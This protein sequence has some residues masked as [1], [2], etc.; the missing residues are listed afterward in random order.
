LSVVIPVFNAHRELS[1]CLAS[2]AATV[3]PRTE[4]IIIDDA[5]TEPE[6]TQ[7]L[8]KWRHDSGRA[9]RFHSNPVNRGFVA[10]A[11]RGMRLAKHDVILLNSDTVVTPRWLDGLRECLGSDPSIATA[12]PWTNNG[13]IVSIPRFCENNPAPEDPAAVAA[14]IAAAGKPE[15]PA[16]HTAVGFCMAIS[17]RA[18]RQV[19]LFDAE[20]FG[21]GYGEEN[22]FC[23]RAEAAGWR[24]VLCDDVYVAHLGGRSFGPAGLAP[25]DSSMQRLLSLHPGYL[26][27]IRTWIDADPLAGRRAAILAALEEAGLT[28]G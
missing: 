24:N 25:D 9:W 5:S 8:N 6:V 22:D 15:Y 20:Q 26:D 18:I 7:V 17:R 23:L 1:Q 12:T 2:V 19:G 10:T 28:L 21:R 14:V 13:E 27:R 4:V 16:L 3:N 11:N